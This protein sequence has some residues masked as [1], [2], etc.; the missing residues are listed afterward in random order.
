[1]EDRWGGEMPSVLDTI[2]ATSA[3]SEIEPVIRHALDTHYFASYR[4]DL[5]GRLTYQVNGAWIAIPRT[6]RMSLDDNAFTRIA[7]RFSMDWFAHMTAAGVP[8][9]RE[10]VIKLLRRGDR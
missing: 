6:V 9:D 5:G 8:M 1:M 4:E 3:G 10:R 7:E 2:N